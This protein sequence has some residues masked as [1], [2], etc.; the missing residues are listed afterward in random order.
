MEKQGPT[1]RE[2]NTM[3]AEVAALRQ[4]MDGLQKLTPDEVTTLRRL[5]AMGVAGKLLVVCL[6]AVTVFAVAASHLKTM[7]KGWL[8]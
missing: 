8:T 7:I 4:K 3:T 5:A 2:W 6:G 1:E